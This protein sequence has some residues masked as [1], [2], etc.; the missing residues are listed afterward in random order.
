MTAV[1]ATAGATDFYLNQSYV[2]HT[3]P[4]GCGSGLLCVYEHSSW[5]GGVAYRTGEDGDWTNNQYNNGVNLNDTASS[6]FNSSTTQVRRVFR[7]TGFG[8]HVLCLAP[9]TGVT[10]LS[11]V[12]WVETSPVTWRYSMSDRISGHKTHA[13]SINDYNCQ[14]KAQ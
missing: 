3:N 2:T 9:D 8:S 12:E 13:G 1:P 4:S 14:W 7:D 10:N 11:H 5:G 6:I